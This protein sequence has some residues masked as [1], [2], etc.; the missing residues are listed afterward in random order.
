MAI[1]CFDFPYSGEY[2]YISSQWQ[3][4]VEN[5]TYASDKHN[6]VAV[7]FFCASEKL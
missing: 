4:C 6:N 2:N 1:F 5:Q 3:V 7:L